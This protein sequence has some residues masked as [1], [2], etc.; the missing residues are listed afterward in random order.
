MIFVVTFLTAVNPFSL[1]SQCLLL[2]AGCWIKKV[3]TSHFQVLVYAYINPA[4]GNTKVERRRV[5]CHGRKKMTG[6]RG[7]EGV[8]SADA[9]A[10][11]PNGKKST[12]KMQSTTRTLAGVFVLWYVPP[13]RISTTHRRP[14][15]RVGQASRTCWQP[16]TPAAVVTL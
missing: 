8:L 11:E 10:R 15:N 2:F 16:S 9:S 3:T 14:A 12:L 5:G 6:M 13:R 7:K 4:K 1:A